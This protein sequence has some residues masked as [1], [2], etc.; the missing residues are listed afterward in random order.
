MS[1]FLLHTFLLLAVLFFGVLLGVYHSTQDVSTFKDKDNVVKVK[2]EV[3]SE[4][5]KP[6][7]EI[8]KSEKV[9]EELTERQI[10]ANEVEAFNFFSQLGQTISE[11]LYVSFYSLLSAVTK[12]INNILH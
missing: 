12:L 11:V 6:S 4:T 8:V 3:V 7:R 9:K 2:S 1:K 10:Y 5:E